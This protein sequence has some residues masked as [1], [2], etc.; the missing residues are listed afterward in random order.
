MIKINIRKKLISDEN[1]LI[2]DINTNIESQ[3]FV[4]LFGK[5]GAGK[6]SI[7][8][9]LIGV[10]NPDEG[11]IIIDDKVI[12]SSE[13]KIN[14]PTQKRGIGMVFQDY[15]LFPHLNVYKNIGFGLKNKKNKNA[16]NEIIE[17]MEL[18]NIYHLY[19]HQLSGGQKQRVALARA[20][21]CNDNKILLLDEPL[22]ALDNETRE[23]LQNEIINWHKYFNLTT[24]LVSHNINE[25]YKLSNRV[26][27]IQ[28][29]KII[30]DSIVNNDRLNTSL[31]AKII[32]I[33]NDMKN[34]S[35]IIKILIEEDKFNIHRD[36]TIGDNIVIKAEKSKINKAKHAL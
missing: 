18:K 30:K 8:K 32:D 4:G 13:K 25:I 9:I 35:K 33:K 28:N 15:A 22:S 11:E 3:S 7:L 2:I 29:G 21:I 31:D 20:I 16:V 34:K 12:F 19:P 27:Q 24:I 36:F 17:L 14:I 10:M 1:P 26:I 5:S 6:T 23:K